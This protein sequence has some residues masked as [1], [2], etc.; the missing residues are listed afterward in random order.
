MNGG[1]NSGG[2]FPLWLNYGDVE[3]LVDVLQYGLTRLV[4]GGEKNSPEAVERFRQIFEQVKAL[5]P[6]P[7]KARN[8]GTSAFFDAFRAAETCD[9]FE[10]FADYKDGR[11]AS[12]AVLVHEAGEAQRFDL[13]RWLEAPETTR[14]VKDP[15]ELQA[16]YSE[17]VE[18]IASM[19]TEVA[20]VEASRLIEHTASV[21]VRDED[22]SWGDELAVTLQ[23]ICNETFGEHAEYRGYKSV[24]GRGEIEGYQEIRVTF[25]APSF[26]KDHVETAARQR[27]EEIASSTV[28][29]SP[30]R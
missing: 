9:A 1:R 23:A 16:M 14:R 2:E 7:E 30:A 17:V 10:V 26:L 21:H 29:V 28:S 11:E 3:M 6:I 12:I 15:T 27:T 22:W 20:P 4:F 13:T 18:R 19:L 5:S 25:C 24:P 8:V